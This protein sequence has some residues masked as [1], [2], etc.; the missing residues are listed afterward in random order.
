MKRIA[1]IM[2][3]TALVLGLFAGS[4]TAVSA[5]SFAPAAEV[6]HWVSKGGRLVSDAS[7]GYSC[8][9]PG[10][11]LIADAADAAEPGDVIHVCRGTYTENDIELPSDFTSGITI[12]GDG[13]NRTFIDAR[14][15]GRIFISHFSPAAGEGESDDIMLVNLRIADMTLRNGDADSS[16]FSHVN[17]LG[18][19]RG[20]AVFSTG[21][22]AC[23]NVRFTN[24]TADGDGGA[25]ASVYGADLE[26]CSFVG[27][28]GYAG[29]AIWSMG[30]VNDRGGIY[31]QNSAF[32][33]GA[34]YAGSAYSRIYSVVY[35]VDATVGLT[36]TFEDSIFTKNRAVVAGGAVLVESACTRVTDVR[37]TQNLTG[38][39]GGAL[40]MNEGS[41]ESPWGGGPVA[42]DSEACRSMVEGATFTGNS[43]L[44]T[45]TGFEGLLNV[46]GAIAY[47]GGLDDS[48]TGVALE[49]PIDYSSGLTIADSTF[50][51]NAA[52][53]GGAMYM[54]D[55]L[56]RLYGVNFY[57][58]RARQNGAS[59]PGGYGSAVYAA[60]FSVIDFGGDESWYAD[61]KHRATF[62]LNSNVMHERGTFGWYFE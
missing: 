21:R 54:E 39:A 59:G 62:E 33:G 12:Q 36:N 13:P 6:D 47:F 16:A 45:E 29:G 14:G 1:S 22:V 44:P 34:V 17:Y 30:T 38:G 7:G 51:S 3:T 32:A 61:N 9:R 19:E 24:N 37:F 28:D 56:V 4:P 42:L 48:S 46:G 57:G 27:N 2:A 41:F 26:R 50:R 40:Y 35:G 49:D 55:G 58:N 20:G 23:N 15:G 43:A 8:S 53:L 11:R 5:T 60:D 31:T 52:A 10:Y 25:L 18:D